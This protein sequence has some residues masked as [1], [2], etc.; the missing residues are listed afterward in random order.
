MIISATATMERQ[1][2]RYESG[3]PALMYPKIE[4]S[5]TTFCIDAASPPVTWASVSDDRQ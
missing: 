4:R 2:S 3:P 1:M 5:A